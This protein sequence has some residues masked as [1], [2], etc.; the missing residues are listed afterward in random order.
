[1]LNFIL[2]NRQYYFINQKVMRIS[3]NKIKRTFSIIQNSEA[4]DNYNNY[5][6]HHLKNKGCKNYR[7]LS[8]NIK[9]EILIHFYFES[10]FNKIVLMLIL[11]CKNLLI[12]MM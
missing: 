12:K 5:K 11:P 10:N 8:I 9:Q 1:M 6:R 4:K 7:T 3:D 2:L